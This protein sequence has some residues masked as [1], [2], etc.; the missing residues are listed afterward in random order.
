[1]RHARVSSQT[2]SR[3][4]DGGDRENNG[5]EEDVLHLRIGYQVCSSHNR[6]RLVFTRRNFMREINET[7]IV[8]NQYCDARNDRH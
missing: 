1:M 8:R 4:L 5:I 2:E 6:A 3:F 7:L